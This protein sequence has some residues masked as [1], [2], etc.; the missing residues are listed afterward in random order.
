MVRGSALLPFG[1]E[2][3]WTRSG[4]ADEGVRARGRNAAAPRVIQT[5]HPSAFGG[6]LLPQGEKGWMGSLDELAG[7][8]ALAGKPPVA[9]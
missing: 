9:P 1:G 3:G 4:Q 8:A 2:G 5:P 6:H 7:G